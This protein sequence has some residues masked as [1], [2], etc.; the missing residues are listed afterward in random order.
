MTKMKLN[1]VNEKYQNRF[2]HYLLII[3]LLF[4]ACQDKHGVVFDNGR[5]YSTK[6]NLT[7][8]QQERLLQSL[9]AFHVNYDPEAKMLKEPFS[10][11]GYHTTLKGGE[12]HRTRKSLRYAV[13]L[14]D[15]YDESFRDRAIGIIDTVLTF[16][17]TN[18]ENDYFGVW[19]W[20]A[21]EPVDQMDPPDRNWADFCGAQLIE[22]ILTHRDRLPADLSERIDK[23]LQYA[24]E[25]IRRRDVGPGY[26]NIA[27]MGTFVTFITSELFSIDSLNRY[28]RDRMQNFYDFTLHHRGFTEY[29]SPTYTM[30]ALDELSRMRKY[31]IDPFMK[32][33]IDSLYNI[34][35]E[36]VATHFHYPTQQ[37][38][39]P[40]SR[41][42]RT[43]L[44]DD[45]YGTLN[46]AGKG[47]LNQFGDNEPE[48]TEHRIQHHIPAQYLPFFTGFSDNR[49]ER[50]TFRLSENPILGTTYLTDK[51]SLGSVN[52]SD[53]WNQR[54]AIL[55]YWGSADSTNYLHVRFLHDFYD[56]S[57]ANVFSV[58]DKDEILSALNFATDGGDTHMKLDRINGRFLAKDLRLRIQFKYL[59]LDQIRLP[60][61][62]TQPI[63]FT[64]G[65]LTFSVCSPV[66]Q[67]EGT[68]PVWTKGEDADAKV[69]WL[70]LIF[71]EGEE[72][73]F[74]LDEMSSA[75][76]GL[77]LK[78]HP[79]NELRAEHIK[80][81]FEDGLLTLSWNGKELSVPF[82]PMKEQELEDMYS[83][84]LNGFFNFKN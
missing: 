24:A 69:A 29:N 68:K 9:E 33:M 6:I 83:S 40:H 16:Q 38:S 77:A 2:S 51:L 5:I 15:T 50:D 78:I 25:A 76:F 72:K 65:N 7:L 17:V 23:S 49:T 44:R 80:Y 63:I 42:Y 32:P 59:D 31:I 35:W 58:Q 75:V 12:V 56:F 39:G 41:C 21:E 79:E 45:F 46:R 1:I 57:A 36:I 54:R 22:I 10:S 14:L 48:I 34:G 30:V 19:P 11:P 4:S 37:W 47:K 18:P 66:Q 55:G 20:F 62:V 8:E 60:D 28:A 61:E 13:A 73:A 52:H 70:D 64:K 71:Y 43:I 53:L 67:F 26:T 82:K 81:G 27:I 74:N 84:N 3:L